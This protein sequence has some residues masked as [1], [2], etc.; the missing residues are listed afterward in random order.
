[1]KGFTM[2]T[3]YPELTFRFA[4]RKSL[5][6]T[7]D[8]NGKFI[9]YCPKGYP[10]K[11]AYDFFEKHRDS[12]LA[13]QALRT[14]ELTE[15]LFEKQNGNYTLLYFGK[16]YP[17][18]FSDEKAL[19]F[20]GEHFTFPKDLS[21]DVCRDTYRE[22]LRKATKAYIT[23]LVDEIAKKHGFTYE[24]VTVKA[25]RSRYGSCSAKKNL[26]FT[27]ALAACSP[28]FINMVVC[29]ELA[30]TVHLNHSADFHALLD[31][32]CPDNRKVSKSENNSYILRALC[33]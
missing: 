30:H 2:P 1:M 13:R 23:P 22:F 5:R 8:I 28:E 31:R 12:L 33:V 24:K 26:N 17:L 18:I 32:I 3:N 21:L 6:L 25:I 11:L 7:V 10:K 27:L 20:D 14:N 19:R 16:R 4:K 9:L 29:H 15:K